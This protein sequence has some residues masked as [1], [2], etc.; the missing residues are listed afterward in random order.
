MF[1]EL[2]RIRCGAEPFSVVRNMLASIPPMDAEARYDRTTSL[3]DAENWLALGTG[4]LL[5]LA[6]WQHRS[7]STSRNEQASAHGEQS[8]PS[9]RDEAARDSESSRARIGDQEPREFS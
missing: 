3:A 8:T 2:L 9:R 4:T 1:S 7:H 6:C 5:L